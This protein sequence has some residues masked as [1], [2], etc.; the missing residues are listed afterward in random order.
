VIIPI[1]SSP[2]IKIFMAIKKIIAKTG[3][4]SIPLKI[5]ITLFNCLNIGVDNEITIDVIGL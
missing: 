4:K 1:G 2:P 3:V 5:G